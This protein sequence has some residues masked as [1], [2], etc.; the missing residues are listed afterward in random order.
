MHRVTTGRMCTSCVVAVQPTG[1]SV[2]NTGIGYLLGITTSS[3]RTV[4]AR[5]PSLTRWS[6]LCVESVLSPLAPFE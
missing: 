6:L 1:V 3:G 5:R 2:G 4:A